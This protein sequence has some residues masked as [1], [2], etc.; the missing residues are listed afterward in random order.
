M[1]TT[2]SISGMTCAHCVRAVF[3]SLAGVKGIDRADVSIG[4]AIIEHDGSVTP[5][6]IRD[7]IA[8][9]G[10]EV[11]DFKIDRRTLPLAP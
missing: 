7:A 9:A 1:T 10:Y 3:T 8:V 5:E 4:Q 11:K 6:Q 2:V